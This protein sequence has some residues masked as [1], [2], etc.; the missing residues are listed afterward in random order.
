MA[1]VYVLEYVLNGLYASACLNIDVTIKVM[2]KVRV[3]WD[4][5]P[6]I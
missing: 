5:P 2:Q 1:L 6:I 4:D 3:V